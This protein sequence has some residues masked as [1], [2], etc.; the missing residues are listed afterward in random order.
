MLTLD[1]SGGKFD[2]SGDYGYFKLTA[3]KFVGGDASA[4]LLLVINSSAN[5]GL[6]LARLN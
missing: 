2:F 3:A 6:I 5:I 1:T 4:R